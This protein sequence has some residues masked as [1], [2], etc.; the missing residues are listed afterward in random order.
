MILNEKKLSGKTVFT[1][2]IFDI[3]V[4][5]VEIS[6]GRKS[7]RECVRHRGGAAVFLVEKD[8]VL[9]VKQFR[10]L[11]GKEV[12]EIP[13]G[14]LE[15]GED[16]L[17]AAKRELEEE[18]GYVADELVPMLKIYP[19]PGYTDEVIH[20]YFAK[21][22]HRSKQKLDDGEYLNV[23]RLDIEEVIKMVESAEIC[24]SKTVVALYKYISEKE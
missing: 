17:I 3:E 6:G 18:T 2:K 19:S 23:F 22:F 16:S 21:K 1:G 12:L 8:K 9:L 7:V 5:E 13:A 15:K 11:Y 4:D 14:K 24:D 20:I 10:Y